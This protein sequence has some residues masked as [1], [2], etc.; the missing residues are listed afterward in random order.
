M[1]PAF[2]AL[3][4]ANIGLLPLAF[5]NVGLAPAGFTETAK[6]AKTARA[7]NSA[8]EARPYIGL[9]AGGDKPP[10]SVSEAEK[11]RIFTQ[12]LIRSIEEWKARK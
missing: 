4:G 10:S 3:S 8:N 12:A 9:P 2:I 1:N 6:E 5:T 11:D 7:L